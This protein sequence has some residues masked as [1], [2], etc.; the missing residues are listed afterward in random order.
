M[1][2]SSIFTELDSN[3]LKLIRPVLEEYSCPSG[4]LLFETGASAEYFYIITSGN[5]IIRYK[6]YDGPAIDLSTIPAGSGVG[7]SAILGN[8][9]YTSD[10]VAGE[11]FTALRLE[12]E[13]LLAFVRAHPKEGAMLLEHLARL[14]STRWK[15]AGEQVHALLK[16]SVRK[17]NTAIM[18]KRGRTKDQAV[19][20]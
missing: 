20:K 16:Q 5:A 2:L 14:V 13:R 4:T 9:T 8:P 6:P 10:A 11:D 3:T 15:D 18:K 17:K 1:S 12:N 19:S 7:W